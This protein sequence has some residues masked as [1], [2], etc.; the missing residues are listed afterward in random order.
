MSALRDAVELEMRLRGF[1]DK[2]HAAYIHAMEQLARYFR[3]PLDKLTC[4]E[5]Q[6]FLDWLISERKLAWA[7][8]NVYPDMRRD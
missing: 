1:A 8:V 2:T 4:I 5:V 7:T 3:R 6:A